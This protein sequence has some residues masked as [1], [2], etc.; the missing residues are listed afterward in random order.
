MGD[1]HHLQ[2][3]FD[4]FGGARVLC[5]GDVMLDRFVYGRVDRVSA[6]AP[7]QIL[8]VNSQRAMLGGVGNV[9]RN[10]VALG[11]SAVL[12]AVT[13][14][15]AAADQIVELAR[16]E[17]RLSPRLIVEA[18]R[19]S[20]VKTRYIAEGQQ[21]LRADEETTASI[22]P[23]TE[24]LVIEAI[25]SELSDADVMVLSDYT[26]GVLTDDVLSVAIA[27]AKAAGVPVI[28]DPKRDDFAAY[29]GVSILTPNRSELA[30]ASRLPCG[31]DAEVE[32]SARKA[33]D[34]CS[35]DAMMVT[36]SEQ[37]MSLIERCD[38]EPLHLA[39]KALEVFDVSG[40]GDTVV[41]TTAVALAAGA[42]LSVA[43]ELANAAGGIVVGKV[44][45]A[46][47]DRDELAAGLP[48][49]EIPS[50]ASKVMTAEAALSVV[51]RWRNRGLKVGLTNGCFDLLHPGHVSLLGEARASCDRLIVAINGDKSVKRLK[52]NN[53]P[54][55]HESARAV[56]LASLS[57]VD[58]VIVFSE[59]TPIP[60]LELLKPH[61]LIKGGDYTID[62][63]VGADVVMAYGGE[64]KLAALVPGH[65]SS[66]VIARMKSPSAPK[67]RSLPNWRSP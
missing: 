35:I 44:G 40:A 41:A 37:G 16:G 56:V 13:G 25:E 36:R 48:A 14:E 59:D 22:S 43:V 45:T 46:V 42:E 66:N 34:D 29:A 10:A 58:M 19:P 1:S 12:I 3:V 7:I 38:S 28:A 17:E 5:I 23:E 55:Q 51:D 50:S 30:A 26:K 47:V 33:M 62:E 11:A 6:E 27:R 53:R 64:V 39:A 20:T 31:D 9:G 67:A 49:A 2:S 60:L 18:G 57:M 61:V 65:S 21:L 8:H 52:G 4:G 24:R 63:V 15:D 54:V 32:A